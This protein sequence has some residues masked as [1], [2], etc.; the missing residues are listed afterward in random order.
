MVRDRTQAAGV[1]GRRL[2]AR[3]LARLSQVMK[4]TTHHHMMSRLK[5]YGGS[6]PP[7]HPDVTPRH[8]G[9]TYWEG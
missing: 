3:T 4:L 7:K 1:R 2:T 9:Y 8:R 6:T 5:V